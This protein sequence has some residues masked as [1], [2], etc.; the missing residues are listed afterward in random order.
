MYVFLNRCHAKNVCNPG[1][2]DFEN[3]GLNKAKPFL[4]V[5]LGGRVQLVFLESLICYFTAQNP[6]LDSKNTKS[7]M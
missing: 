7:K 4:F 6:L 3:A 1:H 2:M 5:L